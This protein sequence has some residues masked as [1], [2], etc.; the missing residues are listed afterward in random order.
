M[1]IVPHPT[2]TADTQLARALARDLDGTFERLVLAHQDRLYTI[3]VRLL[4]DP[5]DAEEV[6]QDA[7]VRAYRA[8]A[9]YP[10]ERVRTLALRGWLAAIV[11][12][13]ARNRY[14]RRP[15]AA[16]ELA[17]EPVEAD[18]AAIPHEAATLTESHR[19]WAALLASLPDR[20]RVP[21]VLRHVDGLS[22][23]EMAAALGRPE[24]TL[25]AQVHR[26]LGLLR[27]AYLR[28]QSA[29]EELSA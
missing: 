3:A 6:A 15:A 26:G 13:L 2:T 12:N 8:I 23:A 20:Y 27:T 14:R 9:G 5:R 16:M 28:T 11:V 18:R 4:G 7:F 17:V 22:F 24:G 1:N 21:V 25:K 10:P 19:A 29:P